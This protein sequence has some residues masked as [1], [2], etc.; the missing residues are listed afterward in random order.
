MTTPLETKTGLGSIDPYSQK[1]IE[2]KLKKI[3]YHEVIFEPET[4]STML[5][6]RKHAL[7][8]GEIPAAA[9]TDHQ[10]QGVGREG[11]VWYDKPGASIMITALHEIDPSAIPQFADL[12]ALNICLALRK[13]SGNDEIKIKYPNDIVFKGKKLAGLLVQNIY[14]NNGKYI[15]IMTGVGINIHY[16]AEELKE[17]PTDYGAISLDEITNAHNSRNEVLMS[18]LEE[19]RHLDTDVNVLMQNPNSRRDL[20]KQWS[21][22][23]ATLGQNVTII[24]GGET[25]L[26]GYVKDTRIGNGILLITHDREKWINIFDSNMKVR[27]TE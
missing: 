26:Q 17:Y 4:P 7:T 20:N 2:A 12:A 24:Q 3:G 6:M 9:Y 15:G 18:I 21:S 16:S 5:T 22:C 11:R 10:T 19:I 25:I 23:S 13:I 1:T 27:I 8:G 14:D